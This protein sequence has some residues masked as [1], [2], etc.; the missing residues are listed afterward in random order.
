MP[1]GSAN[2]MNDGA[3]SG[4]TGSDPW[5]TGWARTGPPPALESSTGGGC[6]AFGTFGTS[7]W[8]VSSARNTVWIEYTHIHSSLRMERCRRPSLSTHGCREC[9]CGQ[10]AACAAGNMRM[11]GAERRCAVGLDLPCDGS[12]CARSGACSGRIV[13]LE[14][15]TRRLQENELMRIELGG[16]RVQDSRMARAHYLIA[17]RSGRMPLAGAGDHCAR[18]C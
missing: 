14:W 5:P 3:P 4:P 9:I 6:G 1:T 11:S 2:G 18:T 8:N 10:V 17:R 7:A 16:D 13:V 12:P 15:N